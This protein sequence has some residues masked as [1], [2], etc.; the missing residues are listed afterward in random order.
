MPLSLLRSEA[1]D[2]GFGPT[3]IEAFSGIPRGTI[4]GVPIMWIILLW[5]LYWDPLIYGNYHRSL[6]LQ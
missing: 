5:G 1:K 2:V 6:G 4:L 3:F